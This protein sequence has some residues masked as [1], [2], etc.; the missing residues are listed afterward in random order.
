M[1]PTSPL[2]TRVPFKTLASSSTQVCWV[3]HGGIVN[4]RLRW[5]NR[6]TPKTRVEGWSDDLEPVQGGTNMEVMKKSF[7]PCDFYWYGGWSNHEKNKIIPCL[8]V[9]QR[10]SDQSSRTG[11][12]RTE[13]E[14]YTT[15]LSVLGDVTGSN[16]VNSQFTRLGYFVSPLPTPQTR[17][18]T[19]V[20]S[21]PSI[22]QQWKEEKVS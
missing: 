14:V 12:K 17:P 19:L 13:S 3:V 9:I 5:C 1:K 18:R 20:K 8:R 7:Y 15:P 22:Q 21:A 2:R 16:H 10:I 6:C 4:L 11:V